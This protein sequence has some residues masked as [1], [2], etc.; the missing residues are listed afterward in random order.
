M[1]ISSS[2]VFVIWCAIV[3]C[4]QKR[5]ARENRRRSGRWCRHHR[6][7]AAGGTFP[8]TFSRRGRACDRCA[9]LRRERGSGF[10]FSGTHGHGRRRRR[11]R[12]RLFAATCGRTI[13]VG[14]THVHVVGIVRA[15][16]NIDCRGRKR[17]RQRSICSRGGGPCA[18]C[19]PGRVCPGRCIRLRWECQHGGGNPIRRDC[20]EAP[21][22]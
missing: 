13:V 12:R 3:Q 22:S 21:S 6:H 20:P 10:N 16:I 1:C 11:R 4:Q 17:K 19:W 7:T 14:L 5:N 9:L 18:A 2:I 8:A 15:V